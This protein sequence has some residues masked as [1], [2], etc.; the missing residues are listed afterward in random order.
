[1]RT[2][3]VR[4]ERLATDA[5]RA[6]RLGH[7]QR[8]QP[9]LA[10]IWVCL[11]PFPSSERESAREGHCSHCPRGPL[12]RHVV[13]R[14]LVCLPEG[15]R[16][17]RGAGHAHRAGTRT[18]AVS[19]PAGEGEARARAG[20][21]RYRRPVW[22]IG[23]AGLPAVDPRG[24]AGHRALARYAD[25]EGRGLRLLAERCCDRGRRREC[26][27]SGPGAAACAAPP[28]EGRARQGNGGKGHHA[29]VCV[30]RRTGCPAI[31]SRWRAADGHATGSR[32]AG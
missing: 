21:E 12:A 3:R 23:R 5:E 32:L 20:R 6:R 10:G 11:P 17:G 24:R 18:R 19:T 29:A 1:V 22:I 25:G 8:R 26:D 2:R 16:D 9:I 27:A 13:S 14:M 4:Y 30:A 7:G 28:R 31:D 15:G